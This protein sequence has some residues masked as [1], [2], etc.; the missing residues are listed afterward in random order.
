MSFTCN[1]C[2]KNYCSK[3]SLKTHQNTTKACL[4]I[5]NELDSNVNIETTNFKC[6]H[7]EKCFTTLY[8][9]TYH[10]EHCS[11][12]KNKVDQK[13]EIHIKK[14][15]KEIKRQALV[16][17][18]QDIDIQLSKNKEKEYIQN[19]KNQEDIHTNYIKKLEQTHLKSIKKQDKEIVDL[20][21]T[22]ERLA[23]KAIK[24]PTTVTNNN[25]NK[26]CN[27]NTFY[28]QNQIDNKID[29]KFNDEYITTGMRGLAQFV[30]DHITTSEEGDVIYTCSD[31]ARQIFKYKDENGNEVVDPKAIGLRNMIK[32]QLLIK[33]QTLLR[34]FT[35]EHNS[36]KTYKENGFAIDEEEYKKVICLLRQAGEMEVDIESINNTNK[37]SVELSNLIYNKAILCKT[38]N[39]D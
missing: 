4:K 12:R 28:N 32:P 5:Q 11:L 23:T 31:R 10:I 15:K 25:N 37:F 13:K 33:A 9:L 36:L 20:K 17:K 22:I 6:E 14:F 30:K 29:H 8:G 3:S 21:A 34:F 26:T 38:K 7:C 24:K 18:K 39:D 19:F 27:M 16:I 1:F 2:S 35:H